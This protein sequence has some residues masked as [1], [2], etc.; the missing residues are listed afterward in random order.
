MKLLLCQ[1]INIFSH[2][3]PHSFRLEPSF[4]AEQRQLINDLFDGGGARDLNPNSIVLT[5]NNKLPIDVKCIQ[6]FN[7]HQYL[8]EKAMD[9][10]LE[11]CMLRDLQLV[12][13][14]NEVN[15]DKASFIARLGSTYLTSQFANL[16][17]QVDLSV[18][19]FLTHDLVKELVQ[20][21]TMIKSYRTVIP[22]FWRGESYSEWLLVIVDTS[23]RT[24]NCIFTKF[25]TI[26]DSSIGD[27][28]K[29]ALC[30]NLRDKIGAI[31]STT[32]PLPTTGGQSVEQQLDQQPLLQWTHVNHFN[33]AG[34]DLN[35]T[36]QQ[37]RIPL[38]QNHGVSEKAT[39]GIYIMYCIEC[40]YFDA[41][42]YAPLES[43]WL[44]I[45]RN[46]AYCIL[47]EQLM[48]L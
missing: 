2:L 34:S 43:D 29:T 37:K 22:I 11:L 41:P 21:Q 30:C 36:E 38:S 40:D 46:L 23:N 7:E 28:A 42:L 14:F 9:A 20:K 25:N 45:R 6:S 4:D 26:I 3:I 44:N 13:A 33:S 47:S 18:E 35:I 15:A 17:M 12:S 27:D 31:L 1:E 19:Q 24:V 39:T 16:L 5:V 32:S 8:N 48:L 10:F